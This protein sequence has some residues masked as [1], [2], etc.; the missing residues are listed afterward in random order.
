MC[1]R[2]YALDAETRDLVAIHT[3]GNEQLSLLRYSVGELVWFV[4]IL[5]ILSLAFLCWADSQT[6]LCLSSDGTL[7]AVGSHDN[8]IY[9]YT[10]SDKGRKYSR[11]GKCTVSIWS[12][13]RMCSCIKKITVDL[14]RIELSQSFSTSACPATDWLKNIYIFFTYKSFWKPKVLKCIYLCIYLLPFENI[15][16][17]N[18]NTKLTFRK[19]SWICN[20]HLKHS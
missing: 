15:F 4:R 6:S 7:L 9:L 2:W 11:Y 20:I 1:L 3:D 16:I 14:R 18:K 17:T 12:L 19:I 8:F 5:C 10:V 13:H